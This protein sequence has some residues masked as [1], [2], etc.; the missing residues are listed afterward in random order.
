LADA[1]VAGKG[2]STT[3]IVPLIFEAMISGEKP[4]AA[5]KGQPT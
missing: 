2:L 4:W 1:T 5:N 3:Q